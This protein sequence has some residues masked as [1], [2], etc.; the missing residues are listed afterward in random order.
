LQYLLYC[1]VRKAREK[2]R[3]QEADQCAT[4]IYP[5]ECKLTFRKA[6]DTRRIRFRRQDSTS[7]ALCFGVPTN[8]ALVEMDNTAPENTYT[9]YDAHCGL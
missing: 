7:G 3:G 8:R 5:E 2:G 1:K 4:H 9:A 6:S